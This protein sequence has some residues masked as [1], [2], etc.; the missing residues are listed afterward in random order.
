MQAKKP[1]YEQKKIL[2]KLKLDP[3]QW[4][5]QKD[6]ISFIQ[7]RN[8]ETGEIRKIEKQKKT[9]KNGRGR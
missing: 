3:H 2:E 5:V 4:Y 8:T 7:I 9:D 1:T 6:N